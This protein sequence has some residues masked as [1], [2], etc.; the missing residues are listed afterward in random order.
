MC[1]SLCRG[2]VWWAPVAAGASVQTCLKR[3]VRLFTPSFSHANT[4]LVACME[5]LKRCESPL[6][7]IGDAREKLGVSTCVSGAWTMCWIHEKN[8]VVAH[9]SKC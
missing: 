1:E 2:I 8:Y 9:L 3:P 7:F 5:L 4:A 6:P